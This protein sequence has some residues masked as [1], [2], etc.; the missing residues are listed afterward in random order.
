MEGCEDASDPEVTM[1]RSAFE[2]VY[3]ETYGRVLAFALRRTARSSA[4]DVVAGTFLVA[5]RRRDDIVGDPLPWLL[6]IARR[7]LANQLRTARRAEAL[8]LKAG[9]ERDGFD[10]PFLEPDFWDTAVGVAL[11]SLKQQ[12]QDALTLI[13]WEELAPDEAARVVGCSG[14]AFRVRL[15]RARGR[16]ARAL[17]EAEAEKRSASQ[18]NMSAPEPEG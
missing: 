3:R 18:R 8:A 10:E 14:A 17:V 5:W 4:D 6:G 13:A 7:I 11:G 1:D 15:H 16:L 2:D 9:A 12:D